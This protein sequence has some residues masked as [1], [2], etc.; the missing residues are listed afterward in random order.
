VTTHSRGLGVPESA[1]QGPRHR[2]RSISFDP[3]DAEWVDCAGAIGLFILSVTVH[4]ALI[5][6]VVMIG[7]IIA[8]LTILGGSPAPALALLVLSGGIASLARERT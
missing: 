6:I 8:H 5:L 3:G 4:A 2:I 7:A 1:D